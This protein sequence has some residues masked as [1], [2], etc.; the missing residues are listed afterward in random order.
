MT[1]LSEKNI[2]LSILSA[3]N[4]SILRKLVSHYQINHFFDN[5]YGVN[6][7]VAN[8][9]I[10][11]G[12]ELIKKIDLSKSKILLIGDTDYDYFVASKLKIDCV[13]VSNGHQ[14]LKQLKKT[15]AVIVDD[16]IKIISQIENNTDGYL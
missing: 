5:I 15:D 1:T 13:L 12:H 7:H 3:S 9:K 11:R 10:E 8:G 6:N 2:S 14:S 16:L 4:Q